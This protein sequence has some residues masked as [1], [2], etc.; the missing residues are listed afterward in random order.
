MTAVRTVL[1]Y[2]DYVTLPNDGKRYEIH[3]GELSVAPTPT[4]RHQ[5]SFRRPSPSSLRTPRSSSLTL[6]ISR[7][8]G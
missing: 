6:C 5:R 7:R 1:T 3:H 8:R 4:F 2:D